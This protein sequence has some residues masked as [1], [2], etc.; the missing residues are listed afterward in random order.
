MSARR[1]AT[2]YTTNYKIRVLIGVSIFVTYQFVFL[3][4]F[5]TLFDLPFSLVDN[6]IFDDLQSHAT[7]A[8]FFVLWT[9]IGIALLATILVSYYFFLTRLV[10]SFFAGVH[11]V[12]LALTLWA[13]R[14]SQQI[15]VYRSG[16]SRHSP[17]HIF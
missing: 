1:I 3:F 12:D 16:S 15:V 4:V 8:L 7:A 14:F 9:W 2:P 11:T 10:G 17:L 13:R 6:R 5:K